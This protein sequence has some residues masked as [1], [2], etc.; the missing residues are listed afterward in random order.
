MGGCS[1][2][3]L[4]YLHCFQNLSLTSTKS[5]PSGQALDKCNLL[6][7]KASQASL[8]LNEGPLLRI[9]LVKMGGDFCFLLWTLVYTPHISDSKPEHFYER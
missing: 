8:P 3:T 5:P 9:L 2:K 6:V 7:G 4:L 1:L